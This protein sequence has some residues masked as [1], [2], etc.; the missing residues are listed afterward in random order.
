MH[1]VNEIKV[2]IPI[3]YKNDENGLLWILHYREINFILM[4]WS[5]KLFPWF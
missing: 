4:S 2:A 5:N 1:M 3:L